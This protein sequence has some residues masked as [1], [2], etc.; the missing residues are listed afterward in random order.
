MPTK[1]KLTRKVPRFVPLT[2]AQLHLLETGVEDDFSVWDDSEGDNAR[3]MFEAVRGDY[4]A[5]TFPWAEEKF[6]GPAEG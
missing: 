6:S 5:G 1:K 2:P 3:G 4:P